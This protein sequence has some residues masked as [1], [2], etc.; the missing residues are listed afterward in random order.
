MEKKKEYGDKVRSMEHG[1]F[2]P[3]VFSTFDGLGREATAFYSPLADSLSKKHSTPYT[4]R[5]SISFSLLRLAILAI[6]GNR[7]VVHL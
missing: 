2:T 4:L 5:C 3:L 6:R 7:S 1:S